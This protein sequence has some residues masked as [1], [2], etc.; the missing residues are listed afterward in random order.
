LKVILAEWRASVLSTMAG[1][2]ALVVTI[3]AKIELLSSWR[4]MRAA[5]DF[6]QHS[7]K[8]RI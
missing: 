6:I 4:P 7:P 2:Q 5:E 3:F 8:G 1:S